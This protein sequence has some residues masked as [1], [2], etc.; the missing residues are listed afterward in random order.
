MFSLV[1]APQHASWGGSVDAR[2]LGNGTEFLR[3]PDGK[4]TKSGLTAGEWQQ[5]RTVRRL[6]FDQVCCFLGGEIS[7]LQRQKSKKNPTETRIISDNWRKSKHTDSV[8]LKCRWVNDWS[9]NCNLILAESY[10]EKRILRKGQILIC[11]RGASLQN[12]EP[13]SKGHFQLSTSLNPA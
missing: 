6:L 11:W 2:R 10:K 9:D 5:E 3:Y 8:Q 7:N 12:H 1:A 4:G 13:T